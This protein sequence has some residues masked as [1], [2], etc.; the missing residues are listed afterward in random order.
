MGREVRLS[1]PQI[2]PDGNWIVV[3]ASRPNYEENRFEGQLYLIDVKTGVS[4]PLTYE[5]HFVRQAS[6]SPSGDRLAFLALNKNKKPQIFVM[7]MRGGEAQPITDAEQGVK[8]FVWSPEGKAL[9]FSTEDAPEKREG[10]E[11]HNKSF[12]VGPS[13]YLSDSA[14]MPTQLW[15]ISSTGEDAKQ[16]TSDPGG[17]Q[18]YFG[19]GSFDWSPDGKSILYVAQATPHSGSIFLCSLMEVDVDSGQ[20]STLISGPTEIFNPEYSPDGK[21]ISLNRGRGEEPGFNPS[22]VFIIPRS[23]GPLIDAAAQID[24]DLSAIWMPDSQS[25]LV[26]G[27]DLT[28]VSVWHQP[29]NEKPQKL[30][31]GDINPFGQISISKKG[32]LAL[33]AAESQK[34]AEVYFMESIKYSPRKLTDFNAEL[35][36]RN[37]GKVETVFWQGPDGFK[38]NGVL[39]FPPDYEQGKKYP[40][41][42]NIHGGP[43][44]TSTEAF[45]LNRQ[46]LAAQGWI[47]FSPNYRGSNN[48]GRDFQRAVIN[49][50]G[51][52]PGKD[53]MAGIAALKKR[54]IIDE[55]RMA[56]TGWSYGGYMTTWLIAHYQGWRAAVA[57]AAV[58]DW[59]DW[60]NLAD[61]NNW[62]GFGL[63]GSPWLNDNAEN[64][65]RQSPIAYAHQIRTPTL[66]L[67]TT[68]DPRVTVTQSY[69]LYHALKD[70]KVPVEFIAYPVG[71]HFPGDPVHQRDLWQR[72]VNWIKKHFD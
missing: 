4:R 55:S 35:A 42:L 11:K 54:G 22:S 63:G 8:G 38:E 3:R 32:H 7:D 39:I 40:L 58:T 69:K 49:D 65:W 48:Q 36:N 17:I 12:R 10:E 21:H 46:W 44:S 31:I 19:G 24:R 28:R 5:R 37:I 60:Y 6:W 41:V 68:L 56:V 23:G 30:N 45:N 51:E 66:I 26:G 16:M 20:Q 27:P 33:V 57:G 61:M 1:D 62:A 67:S 34:P 59:F 18:S 2:S 71:G 53:V 47:V 15:T 70:N 64:Y 50:A 13:V 9:A 29:L 14:P 25:L 43:M 52:G 72:W